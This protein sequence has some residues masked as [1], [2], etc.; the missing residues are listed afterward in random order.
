MAT[1]ILARIW[2]KIV[3]PWVYTAIT[4]LKAYESGSS[5]NITW[6]DSP[7]VFN[8]ASDGAATKSLLRFFVRRIEMWNRQRI[9]KHTMTVS[10]GRH[11]R[12]TCLATYLYNAKWLACLIPKN[13]LPQNR[14]QFCWNHCH[15]L[16]GVL[17]A[18]CDLHLVQQ[19]KVLL[20]TATCL[21]PRVI[22]NLLMYPAP[23][24]AFPTLITI[25]NTGKKKNLS[26]ARTTFFQKEIWRTKRNG[27][28]FEGEYIYRENPTTCKSRQ[29]TIDLA[30][31]C[32]FSDFSLHKRVGQFPRKLSN[33]FKSCGWSATPYRTRIYV[34]SVF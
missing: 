26:W 21:L 29:S 15:W 18:T 34:N 10:R 5:H 13:R 12:R 22:L 17:N 3:G 19:N 1:R 16:F 9:V 28:H 4:L 25:P 31:I 2:T 14:F 7:L 8:F 6:V 30:K 20:I 27:Q 11:T 23:L 33:S 24:R 32:P